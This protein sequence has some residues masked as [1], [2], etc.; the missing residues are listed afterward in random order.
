VAKLTIVFFLEDVAQEALRIWPPGGA[1]NGLI[2]G[3]YY[4]PRLARFRGP[5]TFLAQ[6]AL[7]PLP[8]GMQKLQARSPFRKMRV[9]SL[10]RGQ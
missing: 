6:A 5:G 2:C 8:F 9:I 3:G 4:G 10:S 1:D 7:T